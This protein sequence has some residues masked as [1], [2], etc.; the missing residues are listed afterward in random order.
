MSDFS[1]CRKKKE[2]KTS[3]QEKTDNFHRERNMYAKG[4]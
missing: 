2:Y 3:L 1:Y 4:K